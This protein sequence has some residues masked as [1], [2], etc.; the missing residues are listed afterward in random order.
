LTGP[1]RINQCRQTLTLE[2]GRK[3]FHELYYICKILPKIQLI[4][5]VDTVNTKVSVLTFRR[6]CLETIPAMNL[7]DQFSIDESPLHVIDKK[8]GLKRNK[9]F[10]K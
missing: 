6:R 3:K 10:E 7:Q 8:F 2:R 5:F 9:G 1:T 4:C